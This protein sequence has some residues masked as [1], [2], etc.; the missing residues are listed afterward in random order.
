MGI[1]SSKSNKQTV[2]NDHSTKTS[3]A[4][5]ITNGQ[6]KNNIDAIIREKA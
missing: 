5:V 2:V 6:D 1:C 4:E 3:F